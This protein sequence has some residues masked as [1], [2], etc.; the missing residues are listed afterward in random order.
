MRPVPRVLAASAALFLALA[1]CGGAARPSA[2]GTGGGSAAPVT[3][4]SRTLALGTDGLSLHVLEAGPRE[5]RCVVLLHG[6]RF[7]AETWR[8]CGVLDALA[9]AG[10][11]A[12]AVD[13][14]GHGDS[15]P[16]SAPPADLLGEFLPALG[17]ERAVVV[18]P[19]MSGA[20]ALPAF[21]A[22]PE[23]FL[24]FVP[25]APAARDTL[26]VRSDAPRI[27]TLVV[28]G[29]NDPVFPLAEGRAFAARL[30]GAE[31]AVVER[32]GHACY[33]DRPERFRELLLG[34]LERIAER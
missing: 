25:V 13:L 17:V 4:A 30:P 14:P 15:P 20:W 19:S 29:E 28:W 31:L 24:G 8:E 11:R 23:L 9:R 22:R 34:F 1:G 6:A 32:A 12:V 27:P 3:I 7:R 26:D 16:S 33:L 10:W 2:A 5:A 21:S 18:A